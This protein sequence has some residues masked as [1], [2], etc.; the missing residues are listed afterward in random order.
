MSG[1]LKRIVS[2]EHALVSRLHAIEF[3]P[4]LNRLLMLFVRVG[5]G[6]VWVIVAGILYWALS[7][8]RFK[9]VVGQAVLAVAISL[10]IYWGFKYLFRRSR[11]YI[12]IDGVSARVPP[13]DRYSFPSGHTMNNLAVAMTLALNL[14]H[15]WPLALAIPL[16]LGFLRILYGVHFLTDIVGGALLGAM[17]SLSAHWLFPHMFPHLFS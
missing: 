7:W 9:S 8:A 3:H 15:L 16:T 1:Y 11:P 17:S 13:L 5:D 2:W 14:P 6:W 12:A 10:P 4:F